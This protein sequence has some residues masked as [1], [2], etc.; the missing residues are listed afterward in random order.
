MTYNLLVFPLVY[1]ASAKIPSGILSG[2]LNQMGDF[3]ECLNVKQPNN[4][5]TGKYCLASIQL[6]VPKF[7]PKLE[8]LRKLV[9][10]NDALVSDFDDVSTKC[11]YVCTV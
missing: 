1:D 8:V 9:H 7:L 11:N 3:D 4:E 5:F 6:S 10:S 2:N